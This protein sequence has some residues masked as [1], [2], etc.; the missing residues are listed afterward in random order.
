MKKEE[1]Q[2][3]KLEVLLVMK[4]GDEL[5]PYSPDEASGG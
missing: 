4:T 2:V 1:W 3:P 5:D